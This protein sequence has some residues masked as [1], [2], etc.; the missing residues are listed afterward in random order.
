MEMELITSG[1]ISLVVGVLL[2][3]KEDSSSECL[4][5]IF[6]GIG[7]LAII[8]GFISTGINADV[9]IGF[10][11]FR[12]I[13]YVTSLII[14]KSSPIFMLY[15][16]YLIF[17]NIFLVTMNREDA[18]YFMYLWIFQLIIVSIKV[19]WRAF[20]KYSDKDD[21]VSKEKEVLKLFSKEIP[22]ENFSFVEPLEK[23]KDLGDKFNYRG[24]IVSEKLLEGGC[25]GIELEFSSTSDI[26]NY[27]ERYEDFLSSK[28]KNRI[29]IKKG[30]IKTLERKSFL[31]I[32]LTLFVIGFFFLVG[33]VMVW[34]GVLILGV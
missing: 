7:V 12:I 17:I 34:A 33:F 26:Y 22:S 11:V 32:L 8:G 5:N 4:K 13:C 3:F 6:L 9:I 31:S 2:F 30:K 15:F 14:L 18:R 21:L 25:K 28:N 29:I 23:I 1:L 20:S 19:F 24:V 16:G 27:I 10:R